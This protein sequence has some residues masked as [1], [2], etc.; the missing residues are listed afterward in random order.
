[1]WTLCPSVRPSVRLSVT[2]ITPQKLCQRF[3]IFSPKRSLYVWHLQESFHFRKFLFLD[4]YREQKLII[5]RDFHRILFLRS[6]KFHTNFWV[7]MSKNFFSKKYSVLR[8]YVLFLR[9]YAGIPKI[10]HL[11]RVF[12]KN[13]KRQEIFRI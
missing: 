2:P 8:S 13:S 7:L 4:G 5:T 11:F 6:I 9:L 3:L 12:I 10:L 1:M